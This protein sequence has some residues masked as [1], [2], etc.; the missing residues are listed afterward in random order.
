MEL[1]KQS[2]TSSAADVN[3][4]SCAIHPIPKSLQEQLPCS[5]HDA[6]CRAHAP[7]PQSARSVCGR[8]ATHRSRKRALRFKSRADDHSTTRARFSATP[9]PTARALPGRLAPPSFAVCPPLVHSP[10]HRPVDFV[11]RPCRHWI[12]IDHKQH[13]EPGVLAHEA[14]NLD[15]AAFADQ[16]LRGLEVSVAHLAGG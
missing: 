3:K 8:A 12:P 16:R 14:D 1:A 10:L 2:P 7:T 13:R 9:A 11:R 4:L 15:D 5:P 6:Y